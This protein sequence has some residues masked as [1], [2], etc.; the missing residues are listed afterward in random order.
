MNGPGIAF[1][2][3]SVGIIFALFMLFAS[4]FVRLTTAPAIALAGFAAGVLG[5]LAFEALGAN[6][7]YCKHGVACKAGKA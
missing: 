2:A 3:V 6:A 1:E 4:Q 5:H 7:W